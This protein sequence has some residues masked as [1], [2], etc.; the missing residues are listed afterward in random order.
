MTTK[1]HPP[2]PITETPPSAAPEQPWWARWVARYSASSEQDTHY[3]GFLSHATE[4]HA[5]V[6]G[7][8]AGFTAQAPMPVELKAA[9][10]AALGL[11]QVGGKQWLGKS[12]VAREIRAEPW[13]FLSAL[14][15]GLFVGTVMKNGLVETLSSVL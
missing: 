3:D 5:L 1:R 13:Y 14:F 11:E 9:I 12:K 7:F 4:Y 10:A 15:V 6:I 2:R 8:T